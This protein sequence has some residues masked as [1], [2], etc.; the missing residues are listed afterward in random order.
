LEELHTTKDPRELMRIE[1]ASK[2]RKNLGN[3][4]NVV[5]NSIALA[6]ILA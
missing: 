6:L 1:R 3:N 4:F 5:Q 2:R